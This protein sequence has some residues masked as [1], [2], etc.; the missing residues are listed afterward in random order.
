MHPLVRR[1]LPLL[2]QLDHADRRL[3]TTRV[4]GPATEGRLQL[5]DRRITR[6]ADSIQRHTCP[7]LASAAFDLQPAVTTVQALADRWAWLRWAAIAFHADRPR[8]CLGSIRRTGGLCCV[9][10]GRLGAHIRPHDPAAPDYLT[11]LRAH[12]RQLERLGAGQQL[13]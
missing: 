9:L 11:F 8:L 10:A 6:P 5:P 3:V 12:E 7:R 1:N 4:A 13:Y 2:G